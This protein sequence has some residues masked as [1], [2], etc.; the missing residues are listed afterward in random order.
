[1]CIWDAN[2]ETGV[3]FRSENAFAQG[4]PRRP[5]KVFRVAHKAH[6]RESHIASLSTP[7]SVPIEVYAFNYWRETF[8]AWPEDLVDV[9]LEYGAYALC[10]WDYAHQDS[11]LHLAVSAFSLAIFGRVK[12]LNNLER[13]AHRYYARSCVQIRKEIQGLSNENIDRV[14]TATMLLAT[15]DVC[16]ILYDWSEEIHI[17]T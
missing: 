10:G 15:Y 9:S 16:F 8:T 13:V 7:L 5:R 14:L 2:G 11:S 1:M 12:H 4:K 6:V 17:L 3:P